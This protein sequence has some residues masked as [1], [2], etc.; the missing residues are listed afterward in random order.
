MNTQLKILL[1][2]GLVVGI[3]YFLQT[4]Y[5]LFDI[6]FDKPLVESKKEE[7]EDDSKES[8]LEILNSEGQKIFVTLEIADTQELRKLG[9]S[10]RQELGDYQGMLFIFDTQGE[11]SF[12]M[13]DMYLPL[14][15]IF[16]N[17][18]GYIVDFKKELQPCKENE[19][20]SIM[21]DKPFMYAL[22]VNSGFVEI[23]KIKVGNA[24]I[25]NISSEE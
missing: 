18:A 25:F 14:D 20:F 6:S 21:S 2:I 22:E 15:I 3:I 19:C 8:S 17:Y 1:Y 7:V 5:S 10:G 13:K 23:N 24:V 11:Y 4:K 9:L 16:I 12:W